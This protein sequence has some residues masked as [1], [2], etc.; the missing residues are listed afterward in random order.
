MNLHFGNS[1]AACTCMWKAFSR[2][3]LHFGHSSVACICMWKSF[4]WFHLHF[5]ISSVDRLQLGNCL[6]FGKQRA[7]INIPSPTPPHPSRDCPLIVMFSPGKLDCIPQILG[8]STPLK[9][10]K[11]TPLYTTR[12]RGISNT[13]LAQ[14]GQLLHG[15]RPATL[16]LLSLKRNSCVSSLVRSLIFWRAECWALAS[17]GISWLSLYQFGN[18]CCQETSQCRRMKGLEP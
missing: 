3:N 7:H 12:R 8:E 9:L 4:S 6:I 2:L 10:P 13:F 16:L 17:F 14:S 11:N 5:R 15:C 18:V 1:S